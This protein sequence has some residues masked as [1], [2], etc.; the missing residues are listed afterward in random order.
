MVGH[1]LGV[2][3][4]IATGP[5]ALDQG[6]QRDLAGIPLVREHALAE[7]RRAQRHAVQPADQPP[8]APALDAVGVAG[9]AARCRARSDR[10]SA[11]CA[12]FRPGL[13]AGPITAGK[14]RVDAELE[15]LPADRWRR[16]RGTWKRSSGMTPRSP[17]LDPMDVGS[18]RSF[19]IGKCR[20]H[21]RR[22]AGPASAKQRS[23]IAV[24][25]RGRQG[26]PAQ[27]L[28]LAWPRGIRQPTDVIIAGGEHRIT[29]RSP[30]AAG[31]WSA[32]P[33]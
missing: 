9:G 17:G 2:E 16:L 30:A 24:G 29:R 5:Q 32:G 22:A 6:D 27:P 8:V 21:R 12:A 31:C 1:E 19:A 13:G 3:Q 7:E 33:R 14:S 23:G 15:G 28:R 25:G 20:P 4:P 18:C 10:R 26:A 11:R